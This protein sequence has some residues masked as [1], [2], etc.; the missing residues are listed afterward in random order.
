[1]KDLTEFIKKYS[2]IP[3][4]KIASKQLKALKYIGIQNA[5]LPSIIDGVVVDRFENPKIEGILIYWVFDYIMDP[6]SRTI[7]P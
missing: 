3:N 2:D 6:M 1:M 4:K 7:F 5:G